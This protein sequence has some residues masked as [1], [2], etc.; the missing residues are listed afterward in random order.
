MIK[1]TCWV[2]KLWCVWLRPVNMADMFRTIEQ[3]S[4][5]AAPESG[6]AT[7]RILAIAT[8]RSSA[9]PKTLRVERP[10]PSRERIDEVHSRLARLQPAPTTAAGRARADS[11]PDSPRPW[12][13]GRTARVERPSGNWQ[14]AAARRLHSHAGALELA[15]RNAAVATVT[16][17]PQ[18]GMSAPKMASPPSR[19]VLS[20]ALMQTDG[21]SLQQNTDELLQMFAR[22]NPDLRRQSGLPA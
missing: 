15:S 7:T 5:N 8:M 19:M 1:W 16:Y 21:G 6:P 12:T 13:S 22:G 20:S 18:G 10:A 11:N 9:R 17:A 14:T 4:R 2:R 3:Q